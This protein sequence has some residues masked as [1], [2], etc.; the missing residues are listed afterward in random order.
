MSNPVQKCDSDGGKYSPPPGAS[1]LR[2]PCP[3]FRFSTP[4]LALIS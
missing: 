1:T 2:H 3:Y 4:K